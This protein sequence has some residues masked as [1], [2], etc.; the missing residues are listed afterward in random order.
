MDGD[1]L[2]F[3]TD[4]DSV[5][6]RDLARDPRMSICV[7][8]DHPPSAARIRPFGATR[9]TKVFRLVRDTPEHT[10]ALQ[11]A[12]ASQPPTLISRPRR[13]CG[14]GCLPRPS[15]ARCHTGWSLR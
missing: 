12:G 13:W 8:D 2:L 3:N 7:D 4:A 11:L 15:R 10:A 14:G 5:K 9:T 6:G 1:D